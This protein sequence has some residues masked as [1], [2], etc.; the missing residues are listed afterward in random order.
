M[1]STRRIYSPTNMFKR[2]TSI[3]TSPCQDFASVRSTANIGLG[4]I[5]K[6][7]HRISVLDATTE[8]TIE[9]S[10]QLEF[11]FMVA[12][13]QRAC[14]TMSS[15]IFCHSCW[16]HLNSEL[17]LLLNDIIYKGDGIALMAKGRR[18]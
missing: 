4:L 1:T 8:T 3:A 14:A 11:I 5:S 7:W 15:A 17:V 16:I 10:Y 9:L 6:S 13:S 12:T 18:N 2:K